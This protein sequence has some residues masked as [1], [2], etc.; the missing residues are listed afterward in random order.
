MTDGGKSRVEVADCGPQICA[1]IVWL[2]DPN[3]EK[4][5]P[6]QDGYNKSAQMRN[7]PILGLPLFDGMRPAKAGWEGKVYNPEEG[8]WFDVN[9]WMAGPDK[10]SIKGCVLFICETHNWLRATSPVPPATGAGLEPSPMVAP[11]ATPRR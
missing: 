3:D 9:V 7:R 4:G 8:E 1:R 11:A 6:L 10:L 5:K 2:K